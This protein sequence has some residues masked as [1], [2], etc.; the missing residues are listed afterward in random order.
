MSISLSVYKRNLF[1]Q[2]KIANELKSV[3]ISEMKML[4]KLS[5]LFAV[6]A[7][8]ACTTSNVA[9]ESPS[10]PVARYDSVSG[11]FVGRID[12]D[13][14]RL[15]SAANAA[16]DDLKYYRIGEKLYTNRS[17]TVARGPKDIRVEIDI[18]QDKADSCKVVISADSGEDN[19]IKSQELFNR[20]AKHAR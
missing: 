17:H 9:V 14:A 5:I 13:F 11:E 1:S 15:M 20:M 6:F 12:G 10:A 7:V 3:R 4:C 19:L 8:V 18:Y 16:F 2:K